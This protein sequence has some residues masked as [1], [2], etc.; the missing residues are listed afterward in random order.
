MDPVTGDNHYFFDY[1]DPNAFSNNISYVLNDVN[2]DGYITPSEGDYQ[3]YKVI[4]TGAAL[5]FM[6]YWML[7]FTFTF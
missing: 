3:G 1:D 4:K 6:E 2:S 5:Q 7:G